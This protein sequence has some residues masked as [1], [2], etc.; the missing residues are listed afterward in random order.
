MKTNPNRWMFGQMYERMH[1]HIPQ[2]HYDDYQYV[3]DEAN[4]LLSGTGLIQIYE[5]ETSYFLDAFAV[6]F[7]S[8]PHNPNFY[9]SQLLTTLKKGP[10]ENIMVKG[11]NAGNQHFLL[12]P[13][14]FLP[15]PTLTR[16]QMALKILTRTNFSL[17]D[18]N[19]IY[20]FP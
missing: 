10:I 3:L 13:Q 5:K 14:C 7:N 6:P 15:F 9:Q 12:F 8:L 4:F 17:S 1:A 16:W 2:C 20:W 11:E 18:Q 19:K